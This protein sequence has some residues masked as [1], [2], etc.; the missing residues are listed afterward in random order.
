MQLFCAAERVV[1]DTQGATAAETVT[2][3]LAVLAETQEAQSES[4]HWVGATQRVCHWHWTED[5]IATLVPAEELGV[6][7]VVGEHNALWKV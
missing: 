1:E 6:S 7:T 5:E 2:N 3:P 4:T